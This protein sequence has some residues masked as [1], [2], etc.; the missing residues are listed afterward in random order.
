VSQVANDVIHIISSDK[1]PI[2]LVFVMMSDVFPNA[3]RLLPHVV[4]CLWTLVMDLDCCQG[5]QQRGEEKAEEEDRRDEGELGKE[6][7]RKYRKGKEGGEGTWNRFIS[8]CAEGNPSITSLS[9]S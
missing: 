6:N 7:E 8:F 1:K 2:K 9:P 4:V 3:S 5:G